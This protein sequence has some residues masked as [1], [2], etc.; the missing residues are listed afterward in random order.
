MLQ[1]KKRVAIPIMTHPG[2]EL[3]GK[4]VLQAVT[5]GRTH[6]DAIC[7]LNEKWP[8]AAVTAI[9]DLTVEAEAFGAQVLFSEDDIPNVTGR[10]VS[11]LES[12]QALKVPGLDTGRVQEYLKANRLTAERIQDKPVYGGCIGPFSLAGRLY[13]MTEL[14]MAIY[15]EPETAGLLLE[16]CTE[17]I[18]KYVQAMKETGIDGV[19]MAEPAAGLISNE[20]CL[21]YSTAYVKKIV[22]TVQDDSFIVVLHNCGNTGHCTDAM[23]QSGAKGLHFGNKADMVEALKACPSDRLV[24]GN[25]DPVCIMK[26]A[27]AEKVKEETLALLDATSP[28]DNFILST[29]C[30]VP[31]HIPLENIDAF[32]GALEEYNNKR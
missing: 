16:K 3:T 4:T 27:P 25:L 31:P 21:A 22:D 26:Q 7:A 30:D 5:D 29:G 12:V 9:M 1:E 17:F 10:L 32:Y 14:M 15:L 19:I 28:W 18:L 24:M 2:I 13:D 8:A 20:D 6:A 11:D 23:V